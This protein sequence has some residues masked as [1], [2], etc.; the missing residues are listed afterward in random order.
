[1]AHRGETEEQQ[2][3]KLQAAWGTAGAKKEEEREMLRWRWFG[4]CGGRRG[5]WF[6]GCGRWRPGLYIECEAWPAS[7]YF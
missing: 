4:E 2:G 7:K 1:M 6:D 3:E 5:R